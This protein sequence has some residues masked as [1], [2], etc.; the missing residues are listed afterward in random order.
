MKTSLFRLGTTV[1]CGLLC[2]LSLHLI[3]TP[4]AVASLPVKYHSGGFKTPDFSRITLEDLRFA[5]AGGFQLDGLSRQWRAGDSFASVMHLGDYGGRFTASL[6][7]LGIG[8]RNTRLSHVGIVQR[9]TLSSLVTA[10]P[11]L[12]RY[13]VQQVPPISELLR[14]YGY[15]WHPEATIS[16]VLQTDSVKRLPLSA[17]NLSR[18]SVSSIPG[19]AQTSL[20][21]FQGWQQVSINQV[22]GLARVPVSTFGQVISRYTAAPGPGQRTS[23][24]EPDLKSPMIS[25]VDIVYGP[26]EREALRT[27]TG[28]DQSSFQ[29]Q[30]VGRSCPHFEVAHCWGGNCLQLNDPRLVGG[31]E[32]RQIVNGR[33]HKVRGGHL[34]LGAVCGYQE[35]A[36]RFS[37]EIL[38]GS[39]EFKTV[40]V[41]Q[42]EASGRVQFALYTR[43]CDA[44]LGCTAYCLG[45]IPLGPAGSY[46]EGDR[47]LM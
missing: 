40:L 16:Q 4:P 18:Y 17:L 28:S 31:I 7:Q 14:R 46:R 6:Q 9:L 32:G 13:R 36:G 10:I 19:L 24:G 29:A 3:W 30:C 20:E 1:L 11:S 43:I 2:L 44:I 25:S 41:D 8:G 35:P 15:T 45:P 33:Y 39:R 12:E 5:D 38:L 34:A 22:G 23:Y 27:A 26:A 42:N 37:Y 47:F 21:R